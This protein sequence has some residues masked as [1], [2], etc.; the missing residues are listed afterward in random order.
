MKSKALVFSE[1]GKPEDV[2]RLEEFEIGE[3]A[4]GEAVVKMLAASINPSDLG[5]IG[6][7]YGVLPELPAAGG[8]EGI[9]EVVE[10]GCGE[11]NLSPGDRVRFPAQNGVWRTY[12]KCQAEELELVPKDIPVEQAAMAAVN[13]L[14]AELLVGK[15]ERDDGWIVQNAANSAVGISVI[16]I[17]KSMGIRTANL[18]RREELVKPLLDLGADHVLVDNDDAV[19]AI[20]GLGKVHGM[21]TLGLNAVG[22]QS[23][24]RMAK[25]LAKGGEH[26]T[27]G[28]MTSEPIRF[29]TRY[30][31]FDDIRFSGFW[32]TRWRKEVSPEIAKAHE[33]KVY[34]YLRD[35]ILKLP[36]EATYPLESFKDALAHNAQPRFGKILFKAGE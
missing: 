3:P 1:F 12:L 7:S 11:T 33:D 21:P 22:G 4:P 6:G 26:I 25:L 27:Y 23:A 14:T 35:G 8:L 28:A 34:G 17:A 2:L 16:Q 24:Y 13:P 5:T 9:G 18:V 30:L 29:P 31:I 19:G 15:L 10:M 36:V 20:R 32:V